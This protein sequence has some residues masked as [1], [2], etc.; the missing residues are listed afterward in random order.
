MTWQPAGQVGNFAASLIGMFLLGPEKG[1][2]AT[3]LGL[4]GRSLNYRQPAARSSHPS[5]P[6]GARVLMR[7]CA[8]E[9]CSAFV[10]QILSRAE[11]DGLF[12][13]FC[14]PKLSYE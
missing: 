5:C 3:N 4:G 8:T 11:K 2:S 10:E 7:Q 12:G 9:L 6:E 13:G 14:C 1:S